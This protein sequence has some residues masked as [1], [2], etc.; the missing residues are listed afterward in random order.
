[1]TLNMNSLIVIL[2]LSLSLV[3]FS[4]SYA[5]EWTNVNTFD[6][7]NGGTPFENIFASYRS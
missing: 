3:S 2:V 7:S 1:M 4:N 5:E 6:G